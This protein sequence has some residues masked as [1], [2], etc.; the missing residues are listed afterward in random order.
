MA[1]QDDAS[2]RPGEIY[3]DCS[4]HPVLCTS[5]DGDEIQGIS[6]IDASMPRACSIGFCG[7]VRL[8][9]EDV[10]EARSDWVAYAERRKAIWDG[11]GD[12]AG[13]GAP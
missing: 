5:I 6:L 13:T 10:I 11:D 1:R 8:S 9:I 2:I 12:A 7:V 4:F 3:E